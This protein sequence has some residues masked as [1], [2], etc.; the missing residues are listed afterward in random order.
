M[1]SRAFTGN[2]GKSSFGTFI[3][4]QT[5]GDYILN[6]KAKVT[7]CNPILCPIPTIKNVDSEGNLL[8]KRKSEYL[9]TYGLTA[10]LNKSN[11]SVNL[12]T[13]LDLE[14]VSV[15]SDNSGNSPAVIDANS[16]AYLNYNIDPSGVLFGN[17]VCGINNFENFMVY[18][19]SED[20]P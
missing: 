7:Y 18:N 5:A 12:I 8:L 4:S 10:T 14:G 1:R 19:C 15:I 20:E 3:E 11:L 16:I 2:S 13:K 9:N 6:K 17:S